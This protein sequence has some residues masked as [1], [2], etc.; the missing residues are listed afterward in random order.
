[1]EIKLDSD[2]SFDMALKQLNSI[3]QRLSNI[4]TLL[5]SNKNVFN[6]DLLRIISSL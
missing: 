5:L 4:E 3:N 1:M 2:I 6:F